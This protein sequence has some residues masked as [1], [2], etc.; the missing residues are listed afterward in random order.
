M[1]Q[2][3]KIS[4]VF[5][6]LVPGEELRDRIRGKDW[7]S[8]PVGNALNLRLKVFISNDREVGFE[9]FGISS[10][11]KSIPLQILGLRI[12]LQDGSEGVG[13][14]KVSMKGKALNEMQ[15]LCIALGHGRLHQLEKLLMGGVHGASRCVHVGS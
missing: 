4:C 11:L 5:Y 15:S 1:G 12:S 8:V 2:I 7:R 14:N 6:A 13:L 10:A 3:S 9:D